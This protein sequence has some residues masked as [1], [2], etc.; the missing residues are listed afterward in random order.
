MNRSESVKKIQDRIAET[1][2]R[3]GRD[4]LEVKLVAVSKMFP[5][6]AVREVYDAGLRC[7]GESRAQEFRDKH[8]LLPDD[9]EWHFIG[10][11][12]TN[13]IKYVVPNA[14]L[15]HSV[16][17]LHLAT[18]LSEY[19]RKKEV[20]IAVLME[21]NTSEEASKFGTT[22]E[23]AVDT[24]HEICELPGLAAKGLMTIAP[25]SDN[26]KEIRDAFQRLRAIRERLQN[27]LS[28]DRTGVL[29]MG[30]SHDFE[31]AIM[32]GSTMVRIG[33][34]IFGPRGR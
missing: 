27:D 17:T 10:H 22:A 8:P 16:D 9:V 32:E 28:S 15:V 18:A 6:D 7:F 11:L 14:D 3:C 34:A 29:S 5:A 13:K 24:Y 31:Y 25:Y 1:C 2:Q 20:D 21:V 33:S 23:S 30:M 4:P 12:Q 26:E 19:A